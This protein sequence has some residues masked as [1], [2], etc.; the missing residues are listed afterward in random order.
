M[1][2]RTTT[3]KTRPRAGRLSDAGQRRSAGE[4][5]E[6]LLA[7]AAAEFAVG[8]LNGTSTGQIAA[9]AGISQ[10]YVFRLFSSKKELFLACVERGFDAV[11]ETFR[12]AVADPG[13]CATALDAMG[14]A[15]TEMLA[16]RQKLLSQ[17]QAYA[18]CHDPEVRDVVR[19]RFGDVVREVARLSGAGADE[20]RQFMAVG[21][22]LNV[23]AAIDLPEIADEDWMRR[24]CGAG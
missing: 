10:P 9:R 19:R 4:R 17:M 7:A 3:E 16:D 24:Q 6:E 12:A 20:V 15:Y 8:G 13:E 1:A 2:A 14:K 22:L 18:A 23:A 5:R 11:I 21:M